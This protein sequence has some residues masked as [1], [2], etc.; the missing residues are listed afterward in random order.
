[1]KIMNI[2]S[3]S[4]NISFFI[5]FLLVFAQCSLKNRN[6]P[7]QI[8]K[9]IDSKKIVDLKNKYFRGQDIGYYLSYMS[10]GE[11]AAILDYES[12]GDF[13]VINDEHISNKDLNK[14]KKEKAAKNKLK[15]D[16]NN[17]NNNEKKATVSDK[18]LG[19]NIINGVLLGVYD[20]I[21]SD[22]YNKYSHL[23]HSGDR[24]E[25]SEELFKKAIKDKKIYKDVVEFDYGINLRKDILSI[26]NQNK[27]LY[28]DTKIEIQNLYNIKLEKFDYV[29]KKYF[30]E[31]NEKDEQDLKK[32]EDKKDAEKKSQCLNLLVERDQ[33]FKLVTED[34]PISRFWVSSDY[35]KMTSCD[36]INDFEN[37]Y[38]L[39]YG[40]NR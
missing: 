9:L 38:M 5:F 20:P 19:I 15:I 21:L 1:M 30:L 33:L 26:K 11:Y 14:E 34:K 40:R 24:S 28:F 2:I 31:V 35:E 25:S 6:K 7:D 4:L 39:G 12:F 8:K 36:P 22:A 17:N 13:M 3:K 27:G 16:Q 32:E 37:L 18:F 10:A 29:M 23:I